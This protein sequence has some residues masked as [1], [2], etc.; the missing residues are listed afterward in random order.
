MCARPRAARL[1]VQNRQIFNKKVPFSKSVGFIWL[2]NLFRGWNLWESAWNQHLGCT[3]APGENTCLG[4]IWEILGHAC[5]QHYIWVPSPPPLYARATLPEFG[6]SF[7]SVIWLTAAIVAFPLTLPPLP[8]NTATALHSPLKLPSGLL[9]PLGPRV[10]WTLGLPHWVVL[11]DDGWSWIYKLIK[12]CKNSL[13]ATIC[14]FMFLLYPVSKNLLL[15]MKS[16][17]MTHI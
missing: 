1:G 11:L 3:L 14:S 2:H 5:L 6:H 16:L 12:Q 10:L 9:L 4:C 7:H 8:L 17:V 13:E 15:I